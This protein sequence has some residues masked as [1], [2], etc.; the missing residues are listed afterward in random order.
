M[1]KDDV[2][3]QALM[4]ELKVLAHLGEHSNI[5]NLLGAI[6]ARLVTSNCQIVK[7]TVASSLFFQENFTSSWSTVDLA[8][9]KSKRPILTR[10]H[11]FFFARLILSKRATFISQI[12]PLSGRYDE[13]HPPD[14]EEKLQSHRSF[15]VKTQ[16]PGRGDQRQN[17]Q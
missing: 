5:V 16:I 14:L 8:I 13:S 9:C 1:N 6:T 10:L 2:L 3:L 11:I 12:N 17:G 15:W 7:Q 4:S